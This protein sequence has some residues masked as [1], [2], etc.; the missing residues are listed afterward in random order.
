V[1][2]ETALILAAGRGVR[3]GPMGRLMPKGFLRPDADGEPIIVESIERLRSRGVRRIVL[4]TG[5]QHDYYEELAAKRDGL[6]TVRNPRFADSGS[7]YSLACARERITSDCLVLESDLVYESRALDAALESPH[8]DAVV[9][10]GPTHSGDEV[11]V[12]ADGERISNISKDP[13][14]SHTSAGELVG[15]SKISRALYMRMVLLADLDPSAE[16]E[17]GGLK[18]LAAD[19][20]VYCA[21]VADLVWA[22]IDTPEH[23]ERVRSLIYP[24]LRRMET[25]AP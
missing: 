4:V 20:P 14:L 19:Y 10:S 13:A 3:L 16:Y 22:E 5:H 12:T 15:I 18:R 23:F 2:V 8:A 11:Y 25:S 1:T 17:T 9:V 6:E 21:K 7:L 24:K